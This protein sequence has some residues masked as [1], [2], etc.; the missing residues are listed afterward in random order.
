[1]Y[2]MAPNNLI[3]GYSDP[4]TGQLRY[5]GKSRSG[6]GRA[7][8]FTG[9]GHGHVGN[10]INNLT[11]EGLRPNVVVIQQLDPDC[12]NIELVDIEDGWKRYFLQ[13]GCDLTNVERI[14]W[15]G[16]LEYGPEFRKKMSA[17]HRGRKKSAQEIANRAAALRGK[18]YGPPPPE[19]RAKIAAGNRGKKRSAEVRANMA[20]AARLRWKKWREGRTHANLP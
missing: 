20:A 3:Y 9:H 16:R 8:N 12:T 15:D 2:F 5:V 6:M 19:R 13:M 4:R 1:M 18:K 7:N 17:A 10:W 14:G 11:A